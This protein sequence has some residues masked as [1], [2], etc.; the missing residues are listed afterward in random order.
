MERIKEKAKGIGEK[1]NAQSKGKKAVIIST[2]IGTILI[3]VYLCITI[4]KTDY[5]VLFS[6]LDAKDSG[7]VID[8]LTEQNIKYKIDG[9]SILVP[10]DDISKT[11]M[12]ALAKV[13]LSDGS[14]GLEIFNSDSMVLTDFENNV[15]YQRGLQ[16]EIELMIKSFDEVENCKVILKLVEKDSF[17]IKE[18]KESAAAAICIKLKPGVKALKNN[19]VRAI[20][21]LITGAVPNIDKENVNIAVNDIQ[22][23]T[24]K[25]FDEEDETNSGQVSTD[26]QKDMIVNKEEVLKSKIL[27]VLKPVYGDGVKVSVNADLNFNAIQTDS[28]DY[29]KGVI[30]SEHKVETNDKNK[31]SSNE[32]SSPVD[33]N[34]SPVIDDGADNSTSEYKYKDETKNYQ[35]PSINIT[36]VEAPGKIRGL[37]VS[38][39][40]DEKKVVLDELSKNKI[41]ETV[42]SAVGIDKERGDTVSIQGFVFNDSNKLME[43]AKN[44]MG[45]TDKVLLEKSLEKKLVIAMLGIILLISMLVIYKKIW[46]KKHDEE[47]EEGLD[48]IIDEEIIPEEELKF[49][50]IIFESQTPTSHMESEVKKYAQDKPSQVVDIIKSWLAEDER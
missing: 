23:V 44:D 14:I 45:S 8:Y 49:E 41:E 39:T 3:I 36:E 17:A 11:R 32:S 20:V 40:I 31:L 28:I 50:P 30:V 46:N 38:V 35:I 19:Q 13:D 2:A 18:S 47:D 26:K 37:N 6:K 15:K 25:I 24:D 27:E 4:F 22:L 43:Q 48:E 7:N 42:S 33:N 34:L 16:G 10:K 12:E 21:S 29:S 9:Q 1:W 5:D